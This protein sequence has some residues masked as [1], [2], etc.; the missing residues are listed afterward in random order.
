[1][2]SRLFN[3]LFID[4]ETAAQFASFEEVPDRL[5]PHWERKAGQLSKNEDFDVSEVYKDKAA[6]YAEYGKVI[7]VGVGGFYMNKAG[8]LSFKAQSIVQST[9]KETLTELATILNRHKALEDL[10][11][12]AHNG[13]EFD[14]PYLCRRMLINNIKLPYALSLSGKKPWEVSHIDTLQFW[15]FGDY[16]HF[17]SLDLLAT[18]FDIPSSKSDISGAD[19]N[20]VYHEEGDIN[21]IAKYCVRD[22]VVLAR[23]FLKLKSF[24]DIADD[25]ILI[26]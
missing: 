2:D 12:C 5:K 10:Q 7:C 14:F 19:V 20:R 13:R 24:P 11:L 8:E 22:V 26:G 17:T 9:E 6:I 1:M 23:L 3:V 18:L 16:K 15:K 21:R 25:N 4:I